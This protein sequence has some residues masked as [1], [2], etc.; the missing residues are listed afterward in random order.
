MIT[1][2][3]IAG[4][5]L[6][7]RHR[8]DGIFKYI[9]EELKDYKY[10]GLYIGDIFIDIN[11]GNNNLNL[12][13]K[14]IRILYS[15][16]YLKASYDNKIYSLKHRKSMICTNYKNKT[17]SINYVLADKE[18]VNEFRCSIKWLII[19]S[20]EEKG[21]AYIHGAAARY[22]NKNILFTGDSGSGKSSCLLRL[23]SAGAEII[24]DDNV[25]VNGRK[26]TPFCLKTSVK[27]D[28]VERFNLKSDQDKSFLKPGIKGDL[29]GFDIIIFP[30]IWNHSESKF[31]PI[32]EKDAVSILADIYLKETRLINVPAMKHEEILRR[33]KNIAKGSKCYI[34]YAGNQEQEVREALLNFL[35]NKR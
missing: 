24:S 31:T 3:N 21:M 1:N 13:A 35:G 29:D 17:A 11:A 34:F 15:Y 25:L 16:D 22:N 4:I 14:A 5:M 26:I 12:P 32:D 2:Y 28:M 20:I 23:I 33:Y 6:Q 8:D 7:V 10:D 18:I 27:G 9:N 19:K 30:K